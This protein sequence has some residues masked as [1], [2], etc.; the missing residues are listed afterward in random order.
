MVVEWSCP[1]PRVQRSFRRALV[2]LNSHCIEGRDVFRHGPTRPEPRAL[3]LVGASSPS[4]LSPNKIMILIAS[5]IKCH[6]QTYFS[7][8]QE[9]EIIYQLVRLHYY[10]MAVIH[11]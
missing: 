7:K 10:V 5:I 1:R 9:S 3:A 6:S 8:N 2:L 11:A 4:R